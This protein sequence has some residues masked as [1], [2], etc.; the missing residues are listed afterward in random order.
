MH[1][2]RVRER[3]VRHAEHAP[4]A[5]HLVDEVEYALCVSE[6][7]KPGV[8]AMDATGVGSLGATD[9]TCKHG[10]TVMAR[11]IPPHRRESMSHPS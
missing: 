8:H 7:L 11:Y 4:I 2:V 1:G 9:A 10:P 6:Q 3:R 5:V